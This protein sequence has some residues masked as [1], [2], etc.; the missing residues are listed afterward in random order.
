MT[1]DEQAAG[2]AY[3]DVQ[4]TGTA[5]TDAQI[6][7][8]HAVFDAAR[9]GDTATVASYVDRGG[10]VDLTDDTGDTLLI[11]AAHHEHG[12]LVRA[13]LDRGADTTRVNDRDQTALVAAVLHGAGPIVEHLLA[14]GA[15][16]E[17]GS[18]NA[19]AVADWFTLPEMTELLE[20][21]V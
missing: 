21:E 7:L 9:T 19:H 16:P 20:R 12:D 17:L 1:D 6:A 4:P 13:L 3:T 2:T 8:V 10:P 5:Y 15:D 18:P 11:L 14:A